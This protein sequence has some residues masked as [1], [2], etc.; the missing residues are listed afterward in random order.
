MEMRK[1]IE[2][3][4]YKNLLFPVLVVIL[5][6]FSVITI[7]KPKID[8]L[9]KLRK[10]IS[11]QKEELALL[12]QKVAILESYDQNE[13]KTRVNQIAKVLPAEKNG[14]LGLVIFRS[15]TSEHNLLLDSLDINVGELSTESA[16]PKTKEE[17]LPSLEIN[18]NISGSLD[19]FY[20]F[21]A[22]VE[23]TTPIT[24]INQVSMSREGNTVEGKVTL[25]SYYLNLPK[26]IGKTTR[27]IIPITLEEEKVFQQVIRFKSAPAGETLPLVTS[28]KE[29][30]F[31]Y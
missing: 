4:K 6:L 22:D 16:K 19:D 29:N 24:K 15:L 20:N 30:P 8:E 26:D 27:E 23:Q 13:L 9:F 17:V 7:L 10:N 2:F 1:K 28:G 14:P 25:S 5:I 18:I 31:V 11:K 12:S 3:G 21:L